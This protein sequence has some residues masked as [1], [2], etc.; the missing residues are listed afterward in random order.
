M[1]PQLTKSIKAAA[2][3]CFAISAGDASLPLMLKISN[4]ENLSLMIFRLAG[5]YRFNE[6]AV[7]AFA[8]ILLVCA[9]FL[10]SELESNDLKITT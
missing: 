2:A 10:L 9:G 1:L 6:S 7:I 4:F 8:L 3:F 5:S